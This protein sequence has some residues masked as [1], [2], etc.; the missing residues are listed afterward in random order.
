MGMPAVSI[1]AVI[2]PPGSALRS[3]VAVVLRMIIM[4][5]AVMRVA[6]T[7]VAAAVMRVALASVTAAA[8]RVAVASVVSVSMGVAGG[9]ALP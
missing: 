3:V 7:S 5:A 8:V 6:V 2:M 1:L 4:V 9:I